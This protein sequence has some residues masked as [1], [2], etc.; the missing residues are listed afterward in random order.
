MSVLPFGTPPHPRETILARLPN[1]HNNN[2]PCIVAERK[3]FYLPNDQR[4]RAAN[5]CCADLNPTTPSYVLQRHATC[6]TEG[7]ATNHLLCLQVRGQNKRVLDCHRITSATL[8]ERAR[9]KMSRKIIPI[10]IFTPILNHRSS[11]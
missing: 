8:R 4:F 3:N 11:R 10:S 6:R 5:G 9:Q 7:T 2:H 1:R